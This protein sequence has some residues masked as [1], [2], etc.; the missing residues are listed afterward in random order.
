MVDPLVGSGL[1]IYRLRNGVTLSATGVFW[2][3]DSTCIAY[4]P[5][6]F[7]HR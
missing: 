4:C 1:P 6:P 3:W 2:P 7:S 5:H